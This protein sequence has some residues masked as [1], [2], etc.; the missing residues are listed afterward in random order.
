[1]KKLLALIL[2]VMMFVSIVPTAAFAE[3]SNKNYDTRD[4]RVWAGESQQK[5][6][7]DA[8]R[9]NI[10]SMY[11]SYAVDTAV[12]NSVK[13]ID[14]ILK[15]LVDGAL[16]DYTTSVHTPNGLTSSSDLNDAIVA[17]LRSTIG[18]Q[19]SEYLNKHYNDYYTY[20]TAGHRVFDPTK[21]AGV[22]AKAASEA[23]TSSKASAGIQA[24]ML[25]AY[26]RSA[27]NT[28]A[29]MANDLRNEIVSW[30][31]WADYGFS[32]MSRSILGWNTPDATLDGI[33]HNVD[34]IY[35]GFLSTNGQLGVNLDM[36][37][38]PIYVFKDDNGKE[39]SGNV[40]VTAVDADGKPTTGN[41]TVIVN[42]QETT[43]PVTYSR[44]KV[45]PCFDLGY[46]G[47]VVD[48]DG[49]PVISHAG[50]DERV[51]SA[52]INKLYG[53]KDANNVFQIVE[54]KD[55]KDATYV[56]NVYEQAN[57]NNLNEPNRDV[58][59]F[60]WTDA[61]NVPGADS[62]NWAEYK[63]NSTTNT[64]Y[65]QPVENDS[66]SLDQWYNDDHNVRY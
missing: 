36:T 2:C 10:E 52:L 5:K 30:D 21:Y 44:T 62:F 6:I 33:L 16:K 59:G 57:I 27:F 4:Q 1:M 48:V 31:H 60:S 38:E 32:D 39:Y 54:P 8:L 49:R 9:T 43:V 65:I 25:Y 18:G 63:F 40:E 45:V 15:D 20:D 19:I 64:E 13:T 50:D 12:Y 23:L 7:V 17:G 61:D 42:G 56:M 47:W 41:A 26:Q 55:K 53:T 66:F 14:G 58:G 34:E 22:Y 24:F 37:H 51:N 29:N 46:E 28:V 35:A 3:S 11:G